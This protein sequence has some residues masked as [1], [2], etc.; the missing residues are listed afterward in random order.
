MPL[1]KV[2]QDKVTEQTL[3]KQLKKQIRNVIRCIKS[4]VL[5][6]LI[7]SGRDLQKKKG[8]HVQNVL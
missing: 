3:M 4:D 6:D 8:K 7:M 5:H 1:T 2:S